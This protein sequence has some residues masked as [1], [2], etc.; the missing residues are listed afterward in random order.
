MSTSARDNPRKSL[1][2][3]WPRFCRGRIARLRGETVPATVWECLGDDDLTI[4]STEAASKAIIASRKAIA[5]V[6][7]RLCRTA[8]AVASRDCGAGAFWQLSVC[9]EA[10]LDWSTFSV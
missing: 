3:S 10:P 8:E 1:F 5:P 7:F 9:S 6:V 4:T 2:E